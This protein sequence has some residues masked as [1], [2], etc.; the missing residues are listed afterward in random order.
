L[1]LPVGRDRHSTGLKTEKSRT[2]ASPKFAFRETGRQF[3]PVT[4][5]H[6]KSLCS[7]LFATVYKRPTEGGLKALCFLPLAWV[8]HFRLL[9]WAFWGEK[10]LEG[11][12]T[13]KGKLLKGKEWL[14]RG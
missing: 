10:L 4:M 6:C 1:L 11:K 8:F 9:L 13:A 12:R 3:S 2:A 5:S 14:K 7:I